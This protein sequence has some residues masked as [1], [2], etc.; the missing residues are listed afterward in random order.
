MSPILLVTYSL[1]QLD[2]YREY[3]T[4]GTVEGVGDF[5]RGGHV[6]RT[7]KYAYDRVQLAVEETVLQGL[8]IH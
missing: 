2:M 6:I 3:V 4:M 7:V 8:L 1:Y 5:K